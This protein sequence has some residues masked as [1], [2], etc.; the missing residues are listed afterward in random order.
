MATGANPEFAVT[1]LARDFI[2]TWFKQHEAFSPILPIGAFQLGKE[3][4]KAFPDVAARKG[5]YLQYMLNGGSMDFMTSQGFLFKPKIGQLKGPMSDFREGI[6]NVLGYVGNTSEALTRVALMNRLIKQGKSLEEAVWIARTN[7]DF[8][9]GGQFTK[10]LDNAVP[11]LGA[12]VQ[13]T[14]GLF[15]AFK[16]NP[17]LATFKASQI[18][19]MSFGLGYWGM[20]KFPEW[21]EGISPRE[22]ESGWI[23]PMPYEFKDAQGSMRYP[24]LK[25]PKDYGQRVFGAIGE[26][27]AA[28]S[29]GKE[30][31]WEA[32][33]MSITD[34]F[35][36]DAT[37]WI[38]PTAGAL[39]SYALNKD[40]WKKKDIWK[41]R[42]VSPQFEFYADTPQFWV[43]LGDMTGMSPE[44]LKTSTGE[45][46]PHNMYTDLMQLMWKELVMDKDEKQ[47]INKMMFEKAG[48]APFARKVLRLTWPERGDDLKLAKDIVSL[49][50]KG[51]EVD[52]D[53]PDGTEKPKNRIKHDV[54]K[55]QMKAEDYKHVN[56]IGLQ[57]L[58]TE[59]FTGVITTEKNT[60]IIDFIKAAAKEHPTEGKRLAQRY[61]K[62]K[63]IAM[64]K[65]AKDKDWQYLR[66]LLEK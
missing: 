51:I 61:K 60:K 2:Y 54:K 43:M 37:G 55:A 63:T 11:Y 30:V 22:R 6:N 16:S 20:K 5:A 29:L 66:T 14:R 7:L 42:K 47:K 28:Q 33:Q 50:K 19:A 13:G 26:A 39:M 65:R 23:V 21:Y 41:G 25:I 53:R 15:Q 8:A 48:E 3:M 52:L 58:M 62:Y 38:P 24:Y 49:K 40:F 9:Q 36:V 57:R 12:G 34:L 17:K 59:E 1:N 10:M 35:P 46:L 64:R 44:R 31:D 27:L 45:V 32:L 4:I 18:M 56:D